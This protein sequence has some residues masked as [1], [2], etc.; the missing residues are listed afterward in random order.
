MLSFGDY[1]PPT[2]PGVRKILQ[3][4]D[5][6]YVVFA[7]AD[8]RLFPAV[9]RKMARALKQASDLEFYEVGS[10][11]AE[12]YSEV[13]YEEFV[14]SHLISL[15]YKTVA[16]FRKDGASE[17]GRNYDDYLIKLAEFDL[18]VEIILFG[19]LYT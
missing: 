1:F 12:A 6:W 2:E 17:L 5:D 18:G 10:F 7:A 15:G 16:D 14:A 8:V 11:A 3:V 19:E 4:A 9:F 13:F